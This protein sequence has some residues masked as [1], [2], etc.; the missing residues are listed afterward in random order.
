[1]LNQAETQNKTEKT[2]KYE[3]WKDDKI[4]EWQR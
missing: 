2:Q 4:A 1:M 3:E